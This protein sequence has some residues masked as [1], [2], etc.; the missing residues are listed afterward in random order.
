MSGIPIDI[1]SK[2]QKIV[3]A[4]LGKLPRPKKI[5]ENFIL[6]H[7][8]GISNPLT[9]KLPESYLKIL[10]ACI[11]NYDPRD[12]IV[13]AGGKKAIAF[14]KKHI[15]N[16]KVILG[17][18]SREEFI[19]KV[20]SCRHFVTTSG[21]TATLEAFAL[22]APT[23]FLLPTN[24]SQWALANNL[25]SKKCASER[26]S[27]ERYIKDPKLS[28][29]LSEKEAISILSKYEDVVYGNKLLLA[30]IVSDFKSIL[31]SHPPVEYQSKF[32]TSIGTNGAEVIV[33]EL[34]KK[35]M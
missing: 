9:S 21:L 7:I 8:G 17:S 33:S 32:I 13:V 20:N 4:I 29:D 30:E 5:K 10:A 34:V 14:L 11:N 24:L 22:K 31:N 3:P 25:L 23:A 18:F 28:D 6:I 12:K 26:L 16:K 19:N 35:W 2:N 27:W 1:L 15:N